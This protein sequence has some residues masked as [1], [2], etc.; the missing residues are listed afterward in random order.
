MSLYNLENFKRILRDEKLRVTSQ[1]LEVYKYVFSSHDH[2]EADEIYMSLHRRKIGVSR[3]T[4]YRTMDILY[5]HG[6][7]RRMDIGRGRWLF[8]PRLDNSH[9]DHL[10]C[11]QCGEIEEF[12]DEEIEMRQDVVAK[13]FG[14]SLVRHI[15]QLFGIC[16]NCREQKL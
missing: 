6:F 12:F 14:F 4:V 7:V 13:E 1:R 16:N 10:V 9:H 8:E 3:A 11:V 2:R 5:K 15:H